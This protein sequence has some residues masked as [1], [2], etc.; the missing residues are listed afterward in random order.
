MEKC[1]ISCKVASVGFVV[2]GVLI[3]GTGCDSSGDESRGSGDSGEAFD[4]SYDA[5]IDRASADVATD[6][7]AEAASDAGVDAPPD[8]S[9]DAATDVVEDPAVEAAPAECGNG[10]RE[11]G[12]E[13]DGADL[14]G[15]SCATAHGSTAVGTVTCTS[16]CTL[17]ATQCTWCGDGLVQAAQGEL[18]DGQAVG[19]QTCYALLGTY[20]SGTLGCAADCRGYDLAGCSCAGSFA[21]CGGATPTCADLQNDVA[22]CGACGNVCGADDAC[23]AGHCVTVLATGKQSPLGIVVDATNVYF[24]SA[25]DGQAWKVPI[26]GGAPST[27]VTGPTM[28]NPRNVVLV[29]STLYVAGYNSGTVDTVPIAGGPVTSVVSGESVVEVLATDGANLFWVDWSKSTVRR[30][31]LAGGNVTT[32]D[33]GTGFATA[34]ATDGTHVYWGD[35]GAASQVR[36]VAIDGTGATALATNLNGG[37]F[38]FAVDATYVYFATNLDN[39][40]YVVKK[41]GS[42][43]VS[44]LVATANPPSAITIDG[45]FVYWTESSKLARVPVGGGAVTTLANYSSGLA[46]KAPWASNFSVLTTDANR[47]YWTASG[48]QYGNGAVFSVAKP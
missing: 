2:C 45:G 14:G 47:V 16:G 22:N 15:A 5:P 31:T 36:R 4:A 30:S 18:C 42:G 38:G 19:G 24:T 20:G 9:G 40:L 35:S 27:L 41:D 13:C 39:A 37:I 21:I 33:S 7:A 43:A 6:R 25:G 8:V 11:S 34:L 28:Y 26:A 12:E 3:A 46:S 48:T 44:T 10:V 17:D 23:A 29:G 32:I 1:R